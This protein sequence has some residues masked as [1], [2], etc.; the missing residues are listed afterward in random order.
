MLG[1]RG[2]RVPPAACGMTHSKESLLHGAPHGAGCTWLITPDR[3]LQ[4]CQCR[5][6]GI[7]YAG[8]LRV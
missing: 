5:P 6:T 3:L 7:S 4:L 8:W 2:C 1:G